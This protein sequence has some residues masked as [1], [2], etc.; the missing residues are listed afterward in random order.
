MH[1]GTADL[2]LSVFPHVDSVLSNFIMWL[3][4]ARGNKKGF[5]M[6]GVCVFDNL[7]D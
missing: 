6:D 7:M 2:D 3:S 5:H 4:S 1:R